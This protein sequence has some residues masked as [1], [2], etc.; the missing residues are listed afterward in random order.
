MDKLIER[1]AD[2]IHSADAILITAGAGMGVDSGLPD[3]RG[4]QGFWNAYPP[5]KALNLD[6]L[7]ISSPN[8][9]KT[10]PAFAWGFYGHRRNLYRTTEPHNGYRILKGLSD[11]VYVVTSNVDAAFLKAG[12][13][14]E[15]IVETHGTV[16]WNQCVNICGVG[17]TPAGP[18]TVTIDTA[19]MRAVGDLPTC[20]SCGGA[21]RPNIQMFGDPYWDKRRTDIQLDFFYEWLTASRSKNV[22]VIECGAGIEIPSIRERSEEVIEEV[23]GSLVRINPVH[24]G[25]PQGQIALPLGALDALSQIEKTLALSSSS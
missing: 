4:G 12:F 23:G 2:L 18:E 17:I 10:D 19:S 11:D 6:F 5:Y 9:F 14:P 13:D 16:E 25:V 22:V 8:W 3:F 7:E 24:F 15:R 20:P 21:D 1:A